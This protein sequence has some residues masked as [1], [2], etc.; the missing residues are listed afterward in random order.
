MSQKYPGGFITKSPVAPTST[1]A[2][3][4]WTLDQQQQAQ[5]AGTWPSPPI[6]IEDL[7]STWLY[8]G[9]GVALSINNG[10]NL[11]GQGGLVWIKQRSGTGANGLIDTV[12]GRASILYSE[13][14]GAAT[15]DSSSTEDLTSFNSNG[16]SLGSQFN[17]ACN[18]L[19]QTFTS[20][21]FREQ[22]KFFSIASWTGDGVAGRVIPHNL[23]SAPGC[24]LVK[25]VSGGFGEDW[26]VYH[27]SLSASQNLVLNTTAA[28]A[29]QTPNAFG[30]VTSTG[31][32]LPNAGAGNSSGYPYIAYLFAHD[33]GGFPASGTGST[34]GISCGSCT[35]NADVNLGYEPQWV[36][37]KRT[38]STGDWVMVDNMRGMVATT[39]SDCQQ[40]YANSVNAE[41]GNQY[42]P[43]PTSTGFYNRWINGTDSFI[44]IA[45]RRGPMKTPTTGTSVFEPVAAAGSTGTKL[46]TNFP[47][48]LQIWSL[49]GDGGSSKRAVDRLRGV[50]SNTTTSGVAL[51]TDLTSAEDPASA[52]TRY[53]DNTGFTIPDNFLGSGLSAIY[54]NWGRAPGFFDEVCYTGTGYSST[55]TLTHN[56]SVTPELMIAKDRTTG[57]GWGVYSA[58]LGATKYL[59]LNEAFA[60]DTSQFFWGNTSPTSTQFTVR[61]GT[62]IGGSNFVAYLFATCP[63]VSKVGSFTGTGAT[64]VI[65][66]GFTAGARFVLIKATSTTG[67]WLLWDSARGIVAGDDPYLALNSSAAEVTTTDWVDTA[68]TGFEL[69]NAGGNL[70]NT[71]GVS[72]IFLAI[73]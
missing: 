48:D 38:N 71:N 13:T 53:F 57:G 43:H 16:F 28:A 17:F 11:S 30:T 18:S 54:W 10:I 42:S 51:F 52:S 40:L 66:C 68:A 24:I 73:A 27:R 37:V 58:T 41:A 21:T 72:Y 5:K 60:E 33:A 25:R 8:T 7:F 61:G 15:T 26:Q 12:R 3:G 49:R 63:G 19:G 64:Q 47:V 35:G 56:L 69:S 65:N 50:S 34:N 32:Q 55:Q 67:N 20:W 31:F 4:V 14:A 59:Q 62:N 23:G 39:T 22:P 29:T 70:A 6:F 46:T 45:I 44:Y 9:T 36:M 1:A 2:S